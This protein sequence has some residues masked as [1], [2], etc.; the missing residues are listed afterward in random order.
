[1]EEL[2]QAVKGQGIHFVGVNV[3]REPNFG[4]QA[5]RDFI[6]QRNLKVTYDMAFDEGGRLADSLKIM[7]IPNAIVVKD[8]VILWRGHPGSLTVDILKTLA[9]TSA[10]DCKSCEAAKDKGIAPPPVPQRKK[11]KIIRHQDTDA[12]GTKVAA[13]ALPAAEH[14][15]QG[16][17][18]TEW[19]PG[20]LYL[21]EFWASWCGPCRAAIPHLEELHRASMNNGLT[22]IGV[23]LDRGYD[24]QQ[25]RNFMERQPV[26]PTY[27]LVYGTG[28]AVTQQLNP[29]AIPHAVLIRDGVIVWAGHPEDLTTDQIMSYRKK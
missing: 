14:W 25:I 15:A 6:A 27:A 29:R 9:Q 3:N 17:P 20:E 18:V 12:I 7:G 10:T 2:W 8:G 23:N 11:L 13:S 28:S 1:M 21:L 19:K 24:V 5:I 26:H 22:V 16:T 4:A